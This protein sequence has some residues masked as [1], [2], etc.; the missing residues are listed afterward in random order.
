MEKCS[1][2]GDGTKLFYCGVPFCM[3]C[4]DKLDKEAFRSN[5]MKEQAEQEARAAMGEE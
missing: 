5:L 3:P 4:L 2:C 1:S